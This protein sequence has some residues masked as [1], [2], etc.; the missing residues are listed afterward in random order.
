MPEFSAREKC[1]AAQRE[2]A[3]R[4]RVYGRMVDEGRK[5]KATADREIAVMREIAAEYE[6]IAESDEASERLI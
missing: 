5:Q 6:K 4:V 3:Y 2:V 1:R